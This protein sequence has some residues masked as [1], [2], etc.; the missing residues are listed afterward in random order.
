MQVHKPPPLRTAASWR[1][2]TPP[3]G[4]CRSPWAQTLGTW[5]QNNPPAAHK[6][7]AWCRRHKST[8]GRR[9]SRGTRPGAAAWA[10]RGSQG[11]CSWVRWLRKWRRM[12]RLWGWRV[13]PCPQ[14]GG[15]RAGRARN[16]RPRCRCRGRCRGRTCKNE[17]GV[18]EF[19]QV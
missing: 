14:W 3:V 18:S 11:R 1:W 9:R 2:Q 8:P 5:F 12:R 7:T 6:G 15:W 17:E 13:C 4:F 16:R 10:A 19:I